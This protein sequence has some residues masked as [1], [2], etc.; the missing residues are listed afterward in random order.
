MKEKNK[1]LKPSVNLKC[2][3]QIILLLL[4]QCLKYPRE[5][6]AKNDLELR[7][8]LPPLATCYDPQHI[9]NTGIK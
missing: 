1:T 3:S 9:L 2:Y 5:F 8:L 7:I 4:K 6:L